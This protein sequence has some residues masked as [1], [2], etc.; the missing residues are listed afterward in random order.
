M[1]AGTPAGTPPSRTE[2]PTKDWLDKLD[3]IRGVLTAGGRTLAQGAL[4]WIWARSPNTIPIPGFKNV[5]QAEE[6]CGAVKFGPL[7]PAQMGE[8]DRILKRG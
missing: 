8:I 3:S 6:N 5:K 7:S 4:A 2:R 1:C